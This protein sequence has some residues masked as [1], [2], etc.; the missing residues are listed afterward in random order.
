MKNYAEEAS[1]KFRKGYPKDRK[2]E[3]KRLLNGKDE[4]FAPISD[5]KKLN[6][7]KSALIEGNLSSP[8]FND[9]DLRKLTIALYLSNTITLEQAISLLGRSQWTSKILEILP[10]LRGKNEISNHFKF[11]LNQFSKNFYFKKLINIDMQKFLAL[12][13]SLPKSELYYYKLSADNLIKEHKGILLEKSYEKLA[14]L[15]EKNLSAAICDAQGIFYVYDRDRKPC[16][17]FLSNGIHNALNIVRFGVVNSMKLLPTCGDLSL[18]DIFKYLYFFNARPALVKHSEMQVQGKAHGTMNTFDILWAH[19]VFHWESASSIPLPVSRA[20]LISIKLFEFEIKKDIKS[21]FSIEAWSII[22]VGSVFFYQLNKWIPN[23]FKE[24]NFQCGEL[25]YLFFATLNRQIK[26]PKIENYVIP[27]RK[28]P[29]FPSVFGLIVILNLIKYSHIYSKLGVDI[30]PSFFKNIENCNEKFY[31]NIK[32]SI[33]AKCCNHFLKCYL[34]VKKNYEYIKND[35]T[36]IQIFKIY[37]I[38][39]LEDKLSKYDKNQYSRII[40]SFLSSNFNAQYLKNLHYK[41]I[42]KDEFSST[43]PEIYING[44]YLTDQDSLL[45]FNY[46]KTLSK[47]D[48]QKIIKGNEIEEHSKNDRDGKGLWIWRFITAMYQKRLI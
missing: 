47:Q 12:L 30:D 16:L 38:I 6:E 37:R 8:I 45:T 19:D 5:L 24:N 40:S 4:F 11:L 44:I 41:K 23:R 20:L 35:P 17:I 27:F 31:D 28:S 1:N 9:P 33:L 14:R 32:N 26:N 25:G 46:F 39:F 3:V 10:A 34:F 22:D 48:A 18:E 7:L 43:N 29:N 42:S 36:I 15:L 21:S 2:K 13:K